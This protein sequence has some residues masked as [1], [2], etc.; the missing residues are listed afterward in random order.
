MNCGFGAVNRR[1]ARVVESGGPA[2]RAVNNPAVAF[3]R[4]PVRVTKIL[5]YVS[6]AAALLFGGLAAVTAILLPF[7]GPFG[8]AIG[9]EPLSAMEL[10]ASVSIAGA[11]S[12]GAWLLTRRRLG[13]L[14]LVA[15]PG[16]GFSLGS[17]A[18]CWGFVVF[19]FC[20]PHLLAFHE[21]RRSTVPKDR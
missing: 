6:D 5:F 10:L 20:L 11:V 19:L 8:S 21:S 12:V 3:Q 15:A 2:R 18:L 13:G 17:A 9:D 1:W 16:F 7:F 4:L 14:I